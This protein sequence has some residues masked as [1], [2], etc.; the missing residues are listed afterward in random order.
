MSTVE[1]PKY[2]QSRLRWWWWLIWDI[3]IGRWISGFIVLIVMLVVVAFVDMNTS[4]AEPHNAI[5]HI[6][7]ALTGIYWCLKLQLSGVDM[8]V[9]SLKARK[10]TAGREEER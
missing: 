3:A 7:A 1:Q 2:E 9:K 4:I 5:F 6:W 10:P 8:L